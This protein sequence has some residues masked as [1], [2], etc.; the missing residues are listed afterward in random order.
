MH[1][2]ANHTIHRDHTH[3]GWNNAFKPVLEIAP[4]E[5]V[6]F[7]T[8]D[9]SSGQLDKTST[10]EALNKLDLA[11][12]NPVTGPVYV[13]GARPGDALKVSVLSLQPSG[14][15]WTGN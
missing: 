3:H 12:V 9:A 5:T 14:W 15:G 13:D 11:F 7:E 1:T 10:A 8:K 2:H 4:G 6:Q